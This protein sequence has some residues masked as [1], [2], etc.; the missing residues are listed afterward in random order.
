[1]GAY[2]SLT[3]K[4]SASLRNRVENANREELAFIAKRFLVQGRGS[5]ANS[6]VCYAFDT[7][8]VDLVRME[9]LNERS[10]TV[11]VDAAGIESPP[12]D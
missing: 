4:S 11:N 8:S 10:L 7:T 6:A 5:I 9:L 3:S 1:M 2:Q 12:I